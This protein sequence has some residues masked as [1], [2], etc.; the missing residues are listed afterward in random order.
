M[1][2]SNRKIDINPTAESGQNDPPQAWLPAKLKSP[3]L[4]ES[5]GLEAGLTQLNIIP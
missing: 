2:F 4:Q 3:P 5:G 1:L